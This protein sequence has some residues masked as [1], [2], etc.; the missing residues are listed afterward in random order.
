[1]GDTENDYK[2]V[3]NIIDLNLKINQQNFGQYCEILTRLL[4]NNI[5]YASI[6][7]KQFIYFDTLTYKHQYNPKFIEISFQHLNESKD[8]TLGLFIF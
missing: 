4:E 2:T 5:N 8:K 7:L 6:A 1:M 3:S